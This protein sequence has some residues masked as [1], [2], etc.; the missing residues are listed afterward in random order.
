[1]SGHSKWSTIKRQKGTADIKRGKI[2][3]QLSRAITVA[4]REGTDPEFNAKLRLAIERARQANM[5]KENIRRAIARISEKGGAALERVRAEG[6][7]PGGVAVLVEAITDNRQRTLS[8][9]KHVFEKK[10][11][12]LAE[13]GSVE[14]YFSQQ[15]LITLDL[16]GKPAETT[17]LEAIDLGA[18]DVSKVG[19][20]VVVTTQ[21]ASLKKV[22]QALSQKGY[23]LIES[24]LSLEPQVTVAVK[25]REQAQKLLF[26][27]DELEEL[28]DVEEIYANFDIPDEWLN[29]NSETQ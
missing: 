13:P 2:F 14:H 1:M 22:G 16:Q 15:G 23:Q 6:F 10:G 17:M 25:N 20:K 27:L 29:R 26:F 28:D 8:E 7:G 5:P 19:D 4:A 24:R 11:G 3:S 21:A 12:K 18:S 9:V